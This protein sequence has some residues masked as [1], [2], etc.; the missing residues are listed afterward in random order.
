[1]FPRSQV[2]HF[3]EP[4][5]YT[6]RDR[7]NMPGHRN[8]CA[9]RVYQ[10]GLPIMACFICSWGIYRRFFNPTVAKLWQICAPPSSKWTKGYL[11]MCQMLIYFCKRTSYEEL[12]ESKKTELLDILGKI[13][14]ATAEKLLRRPS[15]VIKRDTLFC[16]ICD[17]DQYQS[18]RAE[19]EE[20]PAFEEI[21][22]LFNFILPKLTRTPGP[23]ISAMV[24]LRRILMH[25]PSSSQMHISDSA[26]GEF[27]L[28]SLRSSIRELRVA[29]G[30]V[31]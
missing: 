28:H 30:W 6:K 11:F 26:S 4:G 8:G 13:C 2:W 16:Q 18:N 21:W 31:P 9:F 12:S 19:N 29:T 15:D 20:H 22:S 14:C 24:A 25:A 5:F 17:T 27:C 1:M 7:M 10:Q 3:R 23:R